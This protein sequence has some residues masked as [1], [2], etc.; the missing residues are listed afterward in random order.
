[1]PSNTNDIHSLSFVLFAPLADF[2]TIIQ[3]ADIR[4]TLACFICNLAS[5]N[6][7]YGGYS[8]NNLHRFL[9]ILHRG[10]ELTREGQNE[11]AADR[12]QHTCKPSICATSNECKGPQVISTQKQ[13]MRMRDPVTQ[14]HNSTAGIWDRQYDRSG[15]RIRTLADFC[16]CSS[17]CEPS[18]YLTHKRCKA[19]QYCQICFFDNWQRGITENTSREIHPPP[20]VLP[21][22]LPSSSPWY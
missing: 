20:L 4:F 19:Q 5:S 2:K 15:P 14:N 21:K 9:V 13:F 6:I 18:I 3:F 11:K 1:M 7:N 10:D 8:L 16:N 17:L 12:A 22:K